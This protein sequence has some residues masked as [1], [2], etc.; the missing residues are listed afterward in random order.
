MY[1]YIYIYIY[2]LHI[3]I[4]I[5]IYIYILHI[6]IYIYIYIY[7]HQNMYIYTSICTYTLLNKV[8]KIAR[9]SFARA[10]ATGAAAVKTVNKFLRLDSK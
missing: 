4:Y 9:I 2:I 3:Y 8:S 6:Y 5:Y 10:G 1:M 7:I